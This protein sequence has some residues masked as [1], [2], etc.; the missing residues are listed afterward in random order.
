MTRETERRARRAPHV[1]Y[2]LL[3]ETRKPS[4]AIDNELAKGEYI[5]KRR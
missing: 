2:V 3:A 1:Q 5:T 4:E